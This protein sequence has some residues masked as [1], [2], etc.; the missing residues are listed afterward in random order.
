MAIFNEGY[1]KDALDKFNKRIKSDEEKSRKEY[2][3]KHKKESNNHVEDKSVNKKH[4]I[5]TKE[6][7]DK[8]K[9]IIINCCNKYEILKNNL[10]MKIYNHYEDYL[11]S[12]KDEFVIG[13]IVHDSDEDEIWEDSIPGDEA[14]E[15]NKLKVDFKE[16]I[17][18]YLDILYGC[19][20]NIKKKVS[21]EFGRDIEIILS[22]SSYCDR[23]YIKSNKTKEKEEK[24]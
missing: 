12:D 18:W 5:I 1:I 15:N 4:G 6:E 14:R 23:F 13:G 11:K 2:L 16:F 19:Y 9:S 21:S 22:K 3:E 20:E 24:S 17:N 8:C 10:D 7:V